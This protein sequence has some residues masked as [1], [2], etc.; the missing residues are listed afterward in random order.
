MAQNKLNAEN[1]TLQESRRG[2]YLSNLNLDNKVI[3]AKCAIIKKVLK[4][5]YITPLSIYLISKDNIIKDY[6]L[7]RNRIL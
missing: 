4:N 5:E 2:L 3:H 1:W 7:R 6:F